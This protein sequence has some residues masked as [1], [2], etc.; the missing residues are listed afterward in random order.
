MNL[1]EE[2]VAPKWEDSKNKGGKTLTLEYRIDKF[3]ISDFF[4]EIEKAWLK[5]MLT[6]IGE[7][8]IGSKHV[9]Y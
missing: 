5:L 7:T 8:I 4:K 3:S 9:N 1:F 2:G 6:L